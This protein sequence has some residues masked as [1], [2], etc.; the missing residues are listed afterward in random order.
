MG[1]PNDM[2]MIRTWLVSRTRG[3]RVAVVAVAA[4]GAAVGGYQIYKA[5]AAGSHYRAAVAA[6]DRGDQPAARRHLT[7]CLEEWPDSGEVNFLMARAARRD[8]DFA[9]A[10]KFLKRAEAAG[11]A[12]DAIEMERTLL[13]GQTGDFRRV[14]GQILRWAQLETPEQD[15]FLEVLVPNYLLRHDLDRAYD[16][17][18]AWTAR[19]PGNVRAQMWLVEV[20]E[21]LRM[22]DRAAE[23]AKA[24]AAAAPDRADVRAKCGQLLLEFHKAGEARPHLERAVELAPADPAARLGLARC[25]HE[26]GD[27]PAATRLLDDLLATSPDDPAVLAVR[28]MVALQ[29]GRADEAVRFSQRVLARIPSDLDALNTLAQAMTQL[30]RTDEAKQYR[31]RLAAAQKDLD[32]LGEVTRA[33]ARAPRDPEPRYRAG[34]ILL[35]NGMRDGGVRW[36]ESALAEDPGYEPARKALAEARRG[37][38]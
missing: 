9:A 6:A 33:V 15:L 5:A 11:W 16:L 21:R 10:T 20:C 8:G 35:R 27:A 26:L 36:L 38:R 30:G 28:G 19:D 13:R 18:T 23:A 29:A 2:G 14:E 31:D 3:T 17:L 7:V 25:L 37:S 1:G 12:A 22:V 24:A 34:V 4:A 32:E